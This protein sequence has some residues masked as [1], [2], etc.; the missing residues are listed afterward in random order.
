[1]RRG[2]NQAWQWL[3]AVVAGLYRRAH[4]DLSQRDDP[5]FWP[6]PRP[7]RSFLFV[8]FDGVL[9]RAENGSFEF[10]PALTRIL[11]SAPHVDLVI[12]SNWRLHASRAWLLSHFPS[13]LHERIVGA[14]PVLAPPFARFAECMTFAN[15]WKAQHVLAIDDEREHFPPECSWVVFTD[16]HE[17]LTDAVAD[18]VIQ[19]LSLFTRSPTDHEHRF[20]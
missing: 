11:A 20:S 12:S 13:A 17:G 14:T 1:M 10:M 7:G 3:W 4:P 5:F 16:R 18:Q 9:H 6:A 15:R 19:R 8:D 2:L